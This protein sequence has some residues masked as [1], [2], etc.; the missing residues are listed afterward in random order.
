M[1]VNGTLEAPLLLKPSQKVYSANKILSLILLM[2]FVDVTIITLHLSTGCP[3][4]SSKEVKQ[5]IVD[6]TV[7]AGIRYV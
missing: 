6:D 7:P 3:S 5:V 1:E 2:L 4:H